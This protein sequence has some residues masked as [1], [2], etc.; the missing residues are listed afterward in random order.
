MYTQLK[1]HHI[2]INMLQGNNSLSE[3]HMNGCRVV[4]EVRTNEGGVNIQTIETTYIIIN[5][6]QGNNSLSENHMNGC[7]VVIEVRT[8][9]GGVNIQT[10][11]TTYIT[12]L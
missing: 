12:L 5:M 2:I 6:L 4:I 9:E 3:N 7:R 11:E 10:I 8:N 1:Q